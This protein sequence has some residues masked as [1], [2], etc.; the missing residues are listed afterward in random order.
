[1]DR[2]PQGR[3]RE[4]EQHT[5]SENTNKLFSFS[6]K[7]FSNLSSDFK[8]SITSLLIRWSNVIHFVPFNTSLKKNWKSFSTSTQAWFLFHWVIWL[9]YKFIKRCLKVTKTLF[10]H[11]GWSDIHRSHIFVVNVIP[12]PNSPS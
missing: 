2:W 10:F 8:V 11:P 1:M 4:R 12:K 9:S 5:K 7:P 6:E 3:P